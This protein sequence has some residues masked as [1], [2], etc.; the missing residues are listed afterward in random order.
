M[1]SAGG[2][3]VRWFRDITLDDLPLVGGKNASLGELHRELSAAGV[4]VPDGFAVT[5]EAYRA[6]VEAGG[7]QD[8][9]GA[10]LREIDGR[11]V[12][13]LAAAGA[14]IRALVEAAPW[15]AGLERA[16][17]D[18]YAALGGEAGEVSVAVRSSATAED[19]P[20][21]S[22]VI[23]RLSDFKSNE[24][25]G[26]L[27]GRDFEPVEENPNSPGSSCGTASTASR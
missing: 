8:H 10:L 22:Y 1:T 15:P 4:R 12:A 13:R 9:I 3:F 25:A 5:A 14:A 11:D 2:R 16:V 17:R 7:L 18:A 19:L 6:I 20:E 23:V 26:L 21:A 27:G 24:Y